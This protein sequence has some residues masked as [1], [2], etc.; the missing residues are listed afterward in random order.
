MPCGCIYSY[1]AS[2]TPRSISLRSLICSQRSF[3]VLL[4]AKLALPRLSSG[5]QRRLS[6]M[7]NGGESNSTVPSRSS[8]QLLP[9]RVWLAWSGFA[10]FSPSS[11]PQSP[12][13][14]AHERPG[15]TLPYSCHRAARRTFSRSPPTDLRPVT[16]AH[17]RY[18]SSISRSHSRI[19]GHAF[20]CSSQGVS[21]TRVVQPFIFTR[22][23]PPGTRIRIPG[24]PALHLNSP[25]AAGK[26]YPDRERS[27]RSS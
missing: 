13:V 27:S 9:F 22:S 2:I 1:S 5:T 15:S 12:L 16:Q 21:G 4:T 24:G 17:S 19:H 25:S 7:S 20:F 23:P 11:S 26:V 14:D 3:V 18:S 8:V 10:P 6:P